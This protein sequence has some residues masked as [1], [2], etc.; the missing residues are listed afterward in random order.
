MAEK[1][2]ILRK[3]TVKICILN[4]CKCLDKISCVVSPLEDQKF[5]TDLTFNP[6]SHVLV[7][8]FVFFYSLIVL[9]EGLVE[10]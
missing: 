1:R 3:R 10:A 2:S 9:F 5:P 8:I 4:F 7:L 6:S